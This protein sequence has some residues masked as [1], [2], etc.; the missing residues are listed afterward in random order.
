MDKLYTARRG[1]G[2]YCNGV[3]IHVRPVKTLAESLICMEVG[4]DRSE[5]RMNCLFTN[6]QSLVDKCHGLRGLGS[7]AANICAVA[8]GHVQAFYE[9]GLHCW[10]MCA[11]GAILI[12]AGGCLRDT[13][14]GPFDLIKR[15]VI[16]ASNIEVA[17][18]LGK[19]LPIQLEIPT[20]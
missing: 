12:E 18:Q 13:T 20:D 11:P 10:D 2:A 6:L 9:F 5:E 16:A 8:S 7:A 4:S 3:P 14:G 1:N 17:E 15:R 19:A